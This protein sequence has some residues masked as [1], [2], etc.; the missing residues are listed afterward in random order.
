M[1]Y[2]W[3]GLGQ[4]HG[5]IADPSVVEWNGQTLLFY[6]AITTDTYWAGQNGIAVATYNGTLTQLLQTIPGYPATIKKWSAS[7]SG[8]ASVAA[9]WSDA[10]APKSGDVLI[11]DN[12]SVQNMSLD[13]D[14]ATI[15]GI[16]LLMNPGY[17]GVITQ[18]ST[19]VDLSEW[20]IAQGTFTGNQAKKVYCSGN[21]I[22]SGGT[23]T[24]NMTNLVTSGANA[25]IS[26][27]TLFCPLGYTNTGMMTTVGAGQFATSTDGGH[28]SIVN[29]SGTVNVGVGTWYCVN[30]IGGD[31][32][33]NT[34]QINGTG[35]FR[36][37]NY[38]NHTI[39]FGVIN[40]PV[41]LELPGDASASWTLTLGA[42]PS[43][44]STATVLSGHA[45]RTLTADIAGYVLSASGLITI[46][47]RGII[48]SSVAGASI[49]APGGITGSGTGAAIDATNISNITT[50]A[51][52]VSGFTWTP[53]NCNIVLTGGSP[54]TIKQTSGQTFYDVFAVGPCAKL[55][56]LAI[57][58]LFAHD[59]PMS[60]AFTTTI[61]DPNLEYSGPRRPVIRTPIKI[62]L[63]RLGPDQE[64]LA[65]MGAY[66]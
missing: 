33:T 64:W 19:D 42:R 66:L 45:T 61:T 38:S 31:S 23:A 57:T 48:S 47:T 28:A 44:G 39:S 22:R 26:S 52:D 7:G 34:G 21:V 65:S 5:Q 27:A 24:N 1:K 11:A 8:N 17:F 4:A 49:N 62:D 20:Y 25:F 37:M 53:G 32:F 2:S 63:G 6:D 40:C 16:Q 58:H 56:A 50:S 30:S 41:S 12:T 29:N 46:S 9:N 51:L 60:G 10:I 55:S 15:T 54:S 36:F 3:E 13:L 59:S 18:G 43:F 35:T 14:R